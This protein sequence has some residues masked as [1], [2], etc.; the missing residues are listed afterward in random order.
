[1]DGHFYSVKAPGL[2][3]VTLP[4]YLGLDAIG[5]KDRARDAAATAHRSSWRWL[6]HSP[7][8]PLSVVSGSA[9]DRAR[10]VEAKVANTTAIVWALTLLGA[11]LPAIGL[12]FM[13]RW[14][15]ERIEPGYGAAAAITLG[16][17]TIV[18]TFATEY[19]DHIAS[20]A[21]GFA[22][23]VLLMRR[24]RGTAQARLW[25]PPRACSPASR[26]ASSTRSA[27]WASSSSATRSRGPQPAARRHLR[28]AAAVAG[29]APALLYNLW[30]LGSPL[31]FAYSDAVAV[32]GRSGH[33]VLGLNSDGFFGITAPRPGAAVDL[34]LSGRGLLTLTPVLG[35]GP[36]RRGRHATAAAGERKLG[37]LRRGSAL[38]FLY[39]TAYWQPLGGGTPGPRFLI[40]VLPFLAVGLAPAFRRLPAHD[41]GPGDRLRDDDGRRRVDL[42]ARRRRWHRDLDSAAGLG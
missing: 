16:V 24:T 40:P 31:R 30:S 35:D 3:A 41:A 37:H 6:A 20:A 4:A 15:A 19:F 14:V 17:G 25:S 23:F 18:M 26:S 1:M 42:P 10:H 22:A 34:L 32:P 36:G 8:A 29:A 2:A 39:N 38:Y 12:L 9:A 7:K 5:G 28:A 13:V 11:V 21:L 27:C 33:A